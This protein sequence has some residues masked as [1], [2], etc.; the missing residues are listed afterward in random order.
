[1]TIFSPQKTLQTTHKTYNITS[2]AAFSISFTRLIF[3][4][5]RRIQG[6]DSHSVVNK[7]DSQEPGALLTRWNV[8]KAHTDHICRH[9]LPL[10]VL[11]QLAG[12]E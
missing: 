10:R 12:L 6:D 2:S 8:G 3:R 11:V 1:M 9:L 7:A 4:S 5:Y